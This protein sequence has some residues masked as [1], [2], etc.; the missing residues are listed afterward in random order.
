MSKLLFRLRN[1]PEDEAHDVRELLSQHDIEFYETSAGNWGISMPGI[2]LPND[3]DYGAAR[4]LLDTY[5]Q[6]RSQR[7]RAEYEL[8]RAE[9]RAETQWQRLRKEPAKVIGYLTVIA[10]LLYLSIRSFY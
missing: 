4:S 8:E 9:G 7:L 3:S 6:E 2:W 1:V 5:Q 10:I